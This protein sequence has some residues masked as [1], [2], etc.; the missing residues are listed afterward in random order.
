[1]FVSHND[2]STLKLASLSF[3]F[4]S[5]LSIGL[6]LCLCTVL[7]IKKKTLRDGNIQ[8]MQ[9]QMLTWSLSWY[10]CLYGTHH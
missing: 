2:V 3:N 1:M 4:V 6:L 9:K 5:H 7:F 8:N 10:K